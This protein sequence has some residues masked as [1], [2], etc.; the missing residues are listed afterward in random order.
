MGRGVGAFVVGDLV[1]G[2]AVAGVGD[3]VRTVGCADGDPVVGLAVGEGAD[4]GAGDGG[5]KGTG[6]VVGDAVRAI[7]GAAVGAPEGYAVGLRV[8]CREEGACV[9][10][11]DGGGPSGRVVLYGCW[12]AS[13]RASSDGRSFGRMAVRKKPN[14]TPT[15]TAPNII[16][17]IREIRKIFRR[18]IG[19]VEESFV[20][21][22]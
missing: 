11:V 10:A 17:T 13:R 15:A 18:E 16:K 19:V 14:N 3:C 4:E 1:V 20:C 12:Y 7:D 5:D 8:G 6:A 22:K 9:G 21:V 2:A